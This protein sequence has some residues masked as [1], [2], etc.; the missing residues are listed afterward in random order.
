M[1]HSIWRAVLVMTVL[2]VGVQGMAFSQGSLWAN[3]PAHNKNKYALQVG[4]TVQAYIYGATDVSQSSGSIPLII[5]SSVLGNQTVIGTVFIDGQY[6][7]SIMFSYT[8][9][10]NGCQTNVVAYN[11]HNANSDLIDDGIKNGSGSDAAGFAFY[12]SGSIVN[13]CV[14]CEQD[15]PVITV[16]ANQT[17]ECPATPVF[18]QPTVTDASTF[19]L[20]YS[21]VTTPGSCAGSY[22]VTRTWTAVDACGNSSSASQTI[23]VVDTQAPVIA[24]VGSAMTIECPA[25]PQFSNPTVS[26]AC[27]SNVSMSFAD[28]TTPGSCAGSYS[29]TRTWTAVDACGNSSSAS[30]TIN[31]VDTQ[32]PVIAGVGSAM[33]I[34]CPAV[35]QFSNPTVSDAC[36]SNVS[37]SFADVTTPGS[38]A[39]SYSV[40]R[41]W[42]AVDA[43]GNSSSASQTITVED[44]TPPVLASLSNKQISY[45]ETPAFDSPVIEDACDSNPSLTYSDVTIGGTPNAY[46]ITRT[47]TATDACGNSSSVSQTISVAAVMSATAETTPEMCGAV[48]PS[49]GSIDLTVSGGVAPYSYLWSNGSTSE[50]LSGAGAGDYSVVITDAKGCSITASATINCERSV[51]QGD[52]TVPPAPY[53]NTTGNVFSSPTGYAT[54]SWEIISQD[55]PNSGWAITSGAN[56]STVVYTSGNPGS[57]AVFQLIRA[58]AQ[59]SS[60][61]E[62]TLT[63]IEPP[64]SYTTFTQGFYGNTGGKDCSGRT[65]TEIINAALGSNGLYLGVSGRSFFVGA[66]QASNLISILPGGGSASVLPNGNFTSANWSS[67]LKKGKINNVLLSQT[68]TLGLN[69]R[70]DPTLGGFVLT[71]SF[72]TLAMKCSVTPDP[73]SAKTFSIPQ[74]VLSALGANNTVANL[75]AFASSV[76]GGG[77][78]NGAS[79]SDINAAVDAINRGFDERRSI[80][81]PVPNTTVS[82]EGETVV[83]ESDESASA[84]IVELP[85]EFG[86]DSNYPNPFNPS[87]T[88][89]YAMK[90]DGVVKLAIYNILGQNVAT[91]VNGVVSAG[92]HQITWNAVND[93]GEDLPSGIYFYRLEVKPFSGG[94]GFV[95]SKKMLLMK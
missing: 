61:C 56:S 27:D 37:M 59:G 74:S 93:G 50:D 92:Y 29:V 14:T 70:N 77:N 83:E 15:P 47:W 33:T 36:D 16:G 17:I 57:S 49:P 6:G 20:T 40:T 51:C 73:N 78:R 82:A 62:F 46:S 71:S 68:I 21:D 95:Q 44:N 24:G 35:P 53:C 43:C 65:T 28:V 69:L 75:F 32:A 89:R 52:V 9:P 63:C 25:V 88:I 45:C 18:S 19:T 84:A 39:G 3:L 55:P 26:D 31:V 90:E 30:Q 13:N 23:N 60:T 38:C 67:L 91:L 58:N 7:K 10:A 34:E 66:G 42:T 2:L 80:A 72:T 22:S 48:P 79:L 8:A 41:T 76:L 64:K 4:A 1:K 12:N 81:P 54:Y 11:G 87:T 85:K 5:R 94:E 86:L